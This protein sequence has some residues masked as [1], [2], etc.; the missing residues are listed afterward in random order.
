MK[1]G[2]YDQTNGHSGGPLPLPLTTAWGV[3]EEMDITSRD[4]WDQRDKILTDRAP[5]K[6]YLFEP[7]GAAR[8][9][10]LFCVYDLE[11]WTKLAL[12]EIK[13]LSACQN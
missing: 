2:P 12:Q 3:E 8:L 9:I 7:K 10:F 11:S 13:P 6:P 4:V 5:S 1:G